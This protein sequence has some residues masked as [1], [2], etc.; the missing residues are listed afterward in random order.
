MGD[1]T[2]CYSA[3]GIRKDKLEA[4][5]PINKAEQTSTLR[6]N[7]SNNKPTHVKS[8][9]DLTLMGDRTHIE[10]TFIP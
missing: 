6:H 3:V 5:N 1:E 2:R 4:E 10:R 8:S 7:Q 9:F